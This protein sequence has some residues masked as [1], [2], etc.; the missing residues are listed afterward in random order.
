VSGILDFLCEHVADIVDS[1]NV[2]DADMSIAL[3]QTD[4][5][6][7]HI[8]VS[9]FPRDRYSFTPVDATAVVVPNGS[10]IISVWHAEIL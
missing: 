1:G 7:S 4:G 10:G 3:G 2:L 8:D 5:E 9:E 6:F